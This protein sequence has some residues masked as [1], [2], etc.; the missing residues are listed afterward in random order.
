MNN[1]KYKRSVK[2]KSMTMDVYT[3]DAAGRST[4]PFLMRHYDAWG[5]TPIYFSNLLCAVC[6]LPLIIH[7]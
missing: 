7:T 1:E 2:K 4:L 6:Y 5:A 3:F